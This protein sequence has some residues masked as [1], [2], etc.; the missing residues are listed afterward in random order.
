MSVT[1]FTNTTIATITI[2]V[3]MPLEPGTLDTDY[4][5]VWDG[6]PTGSLDDIEGSSY[7]S[8]VKLIESV[9]VPAG[10]P[11]TIVITMVAATTSRPFGRMMVPHGVCS[12]ANPQPV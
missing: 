2:T 10:A 6:A 11:E 9:V 12:H 1:K 8:A 5:T 7:Y 3:D 4:F